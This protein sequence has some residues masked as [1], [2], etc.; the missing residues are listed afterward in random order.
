MVQT[1]LKKVYIHCGENGVPTG[2]EWTPHRPTDGHYLEF[3]IEM[4]GK[5]GFY[6]AVRE[7]P[8]MSDAWKKFW[9]KDEPKENLIHHHNFVTIDC[10]GGDV[11]RTTVT[12]PK[13]TCKTCLEKSN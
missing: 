11:C 7:D 10:A 8:E 9:L 1:L 4:P 3:A 5:Q 6:D 13:I 12:K 2:K